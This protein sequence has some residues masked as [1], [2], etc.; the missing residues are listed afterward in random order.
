MTHKEDFNAF[1]LDA[2]AHETAPIEYE[3]HPPLDVFF[4]SLAE[5][6]APNAQSEFTAHVATCPQCQARWQSLNE[7][8]QSEREALS[9]KE[10]VPDFAEVARQRSEKASWTRRAHD[11]TMALLPKREFGSIWVTAMASVT[12]VIIALAVTVPALWGPGAA[13]YESLA[14]LTN[15]VETLQGQVGKLAQEV[16][17]IPANFAPS[18]APSM[19]DLLKLVNSVQGISDPWQRSL[20]I[21]SSLSSHGVRIP[22]G[23]G[24]DNLSSYTVQPGDTWERISDHELSDSSLWPLLFLLNA[25]RSLPDGTPS[26]GEKILLPSVTR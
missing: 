8:L 5:E 7:A 24:W 12:A 26:P 15:E 4:N 6:L 22:E 20:I 10:Q 21:A 17:T 14:A 23:V 16:T 25:E 2:V 18:S 9:S 1:M 19:E 11:A 3:H 13:V